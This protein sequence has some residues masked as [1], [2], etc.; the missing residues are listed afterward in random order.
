MS[1]LLDTG[2]VVAAARPD[3]KDHERCARL[4]AD[5]PPGSLLLPST[6]LIEAC[7]LINVRMGADAHAKFLERISPDLAAGELELVELTGDDIA[8]MAALAHTYRDAGLDPTDVS[9]IALAERL[10]VTQV[11]TLDRRDFTVVRP[12]HCDALTL[13]P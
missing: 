12:R 13:L 7:W 9:V 8:R 3:D 11:A 4:F 6:V 2:P 5:P 1:T 10:K